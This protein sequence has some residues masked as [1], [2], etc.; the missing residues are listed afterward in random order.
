MGGAE[1]HQTVWTLWVCTWKLE[2]CPDPVNLAP[3]RCIIGWSPNSTKSVCT[4][5]ISSYKYNSESLQ[6]V[7]AQVLVESQDFAKMARPS[8]ACTV[9]TSI[10]APLPSARGW[11]HVRYSSMLTPGASNW[12]LRIYYLPD[13]IVSVWR[14]STSAASHFNVMCK[15]TCPDR[16]T[17]LHLS[18][19]FWHTVHIT[20]CKI[21]LS[22]ECINLPLWRPLID[23]DNLPCHLV[24][25]VVGCSQGQREEVSHA[26]G[27]T[28]IPAS[29]KWAHK[30]SPQASHSFGWQAAVISLGGLPM[31]GVL[32]NAN[33]DD[34]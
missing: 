23:C 32:S 18:A 33:N 14:V 30:W 11:T 15:S 17:S 20:S 9:H 13:I 28:V 7:G 3:N 12:V 29:S 19:Y 21:V 26:C 34:W 1:V 31:E 22:T 25:S 24:Q 4:C 2:N 8:R 27:G 10:Q 6:H 16:G 5:I